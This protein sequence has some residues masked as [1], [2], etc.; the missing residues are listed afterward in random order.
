MKT[1]RQ[2]ISIDRINLPSAFPT[3]PSFVFFPR[4]PTALQDA[5]WISALETVP[6]AYFARFQREKRVKNGGAKKPWGR[7][8][9]YNLS[10][11]R[12]LPPGVDDPFSWPETLRRTCRRSR[13]VVQ[14]HEMHQVQPFRIEAGQIDH[15]RGS[16]V[17][18]PAITIDAARDLVVFHPN[19]A[20]V[21]RRIAKPPTFALVETRNPLRAQLRYLAIPWCAPWA[22]WSQTPARQAIEGLL[23]PFYRLQV[24][25]VLLEPEDL[26]LAMQSS[27]QVEDKDWLEV[28]LAASRENHTSPLGFR[29]G[30][31]VYYEIPLTEA[32][33]LGGLLGMMRI[34]NSVLEKM[35]KPSRQRYGPPNLEPKQKARSRRPVPSFR[36]MSWR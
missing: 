27:S 12:F 3:T 19:W 34:F 32:R 1:R 2:Q 16:I 7:R 14:Q 24:L 36:L 33:K 29:H 5:V 11:E 23:A 22:K 31:R 13:S 9:R 10:I 21:A 4:L 30:D 20:N 28:Y 17:S 8:P 26:M 35:N 25:Y 15:R 6:A 18:L